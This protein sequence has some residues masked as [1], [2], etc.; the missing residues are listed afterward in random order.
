MRGYVR[1]VDDFVLFGESRSQVRDWGD[2]VRTRLEELRLTIH[3]DKYRTLPTSKGIDFA[4]SSS[5]PMAD[6]G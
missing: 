6:G 4:D 2:Q 1:Y 5:L 3:P